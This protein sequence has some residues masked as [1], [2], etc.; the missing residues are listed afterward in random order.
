MIELL[1]ITLARGG[2]SVGFLRALAHPQLAKVLTAIHTDPARAWSLEAMAEIANMSRSSFTT[3][4]KN[5]VAQ[6]PGEYLTG[7]RIAIAQAELKKGT[8]LKIVAERVG[9]ASQAGFLRAF[10]LS[11]GQTPTQWLQRSS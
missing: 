8:P 10:K 6:T 9:Y 1:R 3:A 2:G 11:L 5:E 7:W 4:F